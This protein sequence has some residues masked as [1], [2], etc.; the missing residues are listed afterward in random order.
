MPAY[1]YENDFENKV[2]KDFCNSY[3]AI[4]KNKEMTDE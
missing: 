4:Y 1:L 3:N 2:A